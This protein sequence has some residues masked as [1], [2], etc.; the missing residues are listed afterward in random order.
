MN[1]AGGNLDG[2]ANEDKG[3]VELPGSAPLIGVDEGAATAVAG[4][5]KLAIAKNLG[6][7][8]A[9]AVMQVVGEEAQDLGEE[10]GVPPYAVATV[11]GL[12]GE[13]VEGQV[14]PGTAGRELMEDGV[15]GLAA[16][17]WGATDSGEAGRLGR[18]QE[19]LNE[20]P[21]FVS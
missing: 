12:V 16:V 5:I 3:G 13:A 19:G 11:S 20:E 21:L 9:A 10:T 18:L 8:E 2:I 6:N 15:K 1:R 4:E 17:G 7:I 14:V